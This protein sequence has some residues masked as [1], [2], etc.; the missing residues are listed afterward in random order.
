MS[1][2]KEGTHDIHLIIYIDNKDINYKIGKWK[3]LK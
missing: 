3:K 1:P 2:K